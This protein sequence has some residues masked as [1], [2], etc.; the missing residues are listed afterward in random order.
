MDTSSAETIH[1][2]EAWI[3]RIA[4]S[5]RAEREGI[6]KFLA[7][8]EQ[9]LDKAEAAL[10]ESLE[11]LEEAV[12]Q[13]VGSYD[14]D[15]DED[16]K[17]RYELALDD[18]RELKASN[19]LLQEQLAKARTAASA[20]AKQAREQDEH[21][22]WETEKRRILAALE[23]D[24]DSHEPSRRAERLKIEDV[25]K[26][27]D[28]AMAEKKEE[29][30]ELRRQIDELQATQSDS[31][32]KTAMITNAIDADTAVQEERKR[33]HQLQQEMQAKMVQAEIELS[34]ERAKMARERVELEERLRSAENIVSQ[35]TALASAADDARSPKGRWLSR[36]GLTDAD[37]ERGKRG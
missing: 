10:Q 33:L 24:T 29:I 18:L 32:G 9:R 26:T 37:R 19:G 1:E 25:V 23:A 15:T 6:H 8:Q 16:F 21:L 4:A 28:I 3:E 5:L 34:L 27:T 31:A 36:L 17:R 11:H 22:D 35:A 30:R 13:P 20:L 12:S 7:V 14:S 2:P